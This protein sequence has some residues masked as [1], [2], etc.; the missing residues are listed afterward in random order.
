MKNQMKRVQ[1]GFTLIELMIVIAI[2]GILAAIAIPAYQ[3][4][5]V[6]ARISEGISM[7]APAKLAVSE[8]R[9]SEG[10]WPGFLAGAGASAVLTDMVENITIITGGNIYIDIN[11]DNTGA[12]NT[13]CGGN[14]FIRMEPNQATGATEWTCTGVDNNDGSDVPLV[15]ACARLLPSSCRN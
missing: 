1:K 8:F 12:V 7:M 4:Y 11:E 3:D 9:Q 10:S 13:D 2:L 15:A 6:R 5:A 14:I